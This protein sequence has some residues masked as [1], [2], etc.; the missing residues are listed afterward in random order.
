MICINEIIRK[1][2]TPFLIQPQLITIFTNKF[3]DVERIDERNGG[4]SPVATK[5]VAAK[6]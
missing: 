4:R 5:Q 1:K 3:N 2:K 6:R